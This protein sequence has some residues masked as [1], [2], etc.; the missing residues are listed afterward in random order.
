M[1]NL[2]L[3]ESFDI[4]LSEK[5]L[6]ENKYFNF[7]AELESK[8]SK[9]EHICLTTHVG[10]D[11]DARSSLDVMYN[12]LT[13]KYPS[14]DIRTLKDQEIIQMSDEDLLILL[15]VNNISRADCKV[16]GY[17][18]IA[19]VD[20]HPNPMIADVNVNIPE[21]GATSVLV[22]LF[23]KYMNYDIS[24]KDAEL[25]F[26]GINSDTGRFL[27]SLDPMILEAIQ[28]LLTRGIDYKKIYAQMYM[29]SPES[30]KI[31]SYILNNFKIMPNG[32]AYIYIDNKI[33]NKFKTTVSTMGQFV[34]ELADIKGSPIWMAILDHGN[35]IN[36]RLRSRD[37]PVD[38]IDSTY[39]G[40]GHE[41]ASGIRLK[42]KAEVKKFLYDIDERLMKFK[43]KKI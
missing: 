34:Y 3:L 1:I 30:L 39:G 40:G 38:D 29:K 24:V 20:H 43:G 31:K 13:D 16:G 17:P 26:G 10:A 21:A 23:A 15:D 32:T 19:I 7:F 11:R 5:R 37:I 9:T 33:A 2:Q 42:N 35:H 41:N 6:P 4:L 8:I 14:K 22:T 12:L 28:F 27:Y 18:I 25:L 36:I